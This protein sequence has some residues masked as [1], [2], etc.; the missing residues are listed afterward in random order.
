HLHPLVFVA[1][2]ARTREHPMEHAAEREDVSPAIDREAHHLLRSHVA[3]LAFN[4]ADPRLLEAASSVRDP[5]VGELRLAFEREQDIA[6]A[7]VAMND[8]ERTSFSVAR[9][10]NVSERFAD[11][12]RDGERDLARERNLRCR[13]GLRE[14]REIDAF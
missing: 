9:G 7:D 3:S 10:V 2:R 1:Y 11:L 13:Y 4:E 12:D 5:E 8:R 14:I 6:R